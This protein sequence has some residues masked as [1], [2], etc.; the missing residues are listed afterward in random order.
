MFGRYWHPVDGLPID[1][2]TR[3]NGRSLQPFLHLLGLR[4]IVLADK[5]L[6]ETLALGVV[7]H[8]PHQRSYLTEVVV[9]CA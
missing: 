1:K 8:F 6:D 9:I 4:G 5:R 3:Q 7:E 2:S